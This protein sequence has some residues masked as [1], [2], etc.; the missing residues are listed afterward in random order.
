[1]CPQETPVF[2]STPDW[3]KSAE[4]IGLQVVVGQ[5]GV[6]HDAALRSGLEVLVAV[7]RH[8][9][10]PAR[11]GLSVD[12]VGAVDPCERPAA[13]LE[14]AAHPLAGDNLHGDSPLSRASPSSWA[15]ASQ[16]SAA[17]RRLA[18]TSSRVSPWV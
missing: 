6:A 16:P 5:S 14:H 17:S 15:T 12:V 8:H 3:K 2:G 11:G 18:R 9:G 10:A 4:L 13:L 1:L 7:D